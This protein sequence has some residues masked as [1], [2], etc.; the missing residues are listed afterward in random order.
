VKLIYPDETASGRVAQ[1][2]VLFV[3]GSSVI[4]PG[5]GPPFDA[6]ASK[7]FRRSASLSRSASFARTSITTEILTIVD[8]WSLL[9]DGGS[10]TGEMVTL[11]SAWNNRHPYRRLYN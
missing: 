6:T 7:L 10:L 3:G 4:D 2:I 9:A 5:D 11:T 8:A 1:L